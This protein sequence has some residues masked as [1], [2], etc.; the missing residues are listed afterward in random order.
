MITYK[1]KRT[2]PTLTK[3]KIKVHDLKAVKVTQR[4]RDRETERQTDRQTDRDSQTAS[5]TDRERERVCTGLAA[6]HERQLE[7]AMDG[8]CEPF[9]SL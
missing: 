7:F 3:S 2:L 9:H 1:I 4:E 8:F 6:S 5:Q